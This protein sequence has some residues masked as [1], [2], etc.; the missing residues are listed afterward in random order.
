[1]DIVGVG[2]ADFEF[3][4]AVVVPDVELS[5]ACLVVEIPDPEGVLPL[6]GSKSPLERRFGGT[7]IGVARGGGGH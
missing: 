1:M 2:V 4:A 6:V 3:A 7:M 5:S